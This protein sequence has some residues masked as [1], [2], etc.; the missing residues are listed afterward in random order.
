MRAHIL[1]RI[2]Q[3]DFLC[4]GNAV[5]GDKRRA[6]LFVKNY[7]SALGPERDF[8]GIRKGINAFFKCSAGFVARLNLF[9]HYYN[10]LYH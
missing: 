5:V 1:E 10:L 7:V 6:V 2:F 4:N 8:N 3:F 9:S